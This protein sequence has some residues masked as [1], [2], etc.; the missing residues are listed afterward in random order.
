MRRRC[1]I[2]L[3][4][5][6]GRRDLQLRAATRF[7]GEH[8]NIEV[9][10][11]SGIV[12][13]PALLPENA[14][15]EWDIAFLNQVIAI[16]T[17]L[18]ASPLLGVLKQCEAALGR[19]VRDRWGPREIDCDLL[20]Y[21]DS[22]LQTESLT[23]PHAQMA[24]RDFVLVPLAEIAPGLVVPGTGKAVETLLGRL[25]H[26]EV[27]PYV[28]T[29]TRIMGIVNVT[30]DSFSDRAGMDEAL[31]R[32]AAFE[33]AGVDVIDIGGESTRPGAQVLSSEEEWARIAPVLAACRERSW[34]LSVDTYHAETVRRALAAGAEWINDVSG[35]RDAAL[36]EAAVEH[37]ATLVAMHSLSVPADPAQVMA[38][39]VNPVEAIIGWA[40]GMIA[41]AAKAGLSADKLVLDPGLGFG[42]TA[43]Q[44]LD[45]LMHMDD[46]MRAVPEVRWLVGH[47]R[48]SF[49]KLFSDV[50]ADKRDGMTLAFSAVLMEMGV[51]YVRVHDAVGH[52]RF[53]EM[54]V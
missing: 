39:E 34:V 41:H 18:E 29:R 53:A 16:D 51:D 31:T 52:Q 19:Q 5:N 37:R 44:S 6:L 42:K 38:A 43:L 36:L 14:P 1:Y 20:I 47:S 11:V 13:T 27:K 46:I 50:A 12:E 30:P 25:P 32:I 8:P 17:D 24:A 22:V 9:M 35:A 7:L 40:K 21:G 26:I 33:Y 4:A 10:A 2:G 54:W 48:K 49:M 23:V 15:P 28:P 3:G 45:I